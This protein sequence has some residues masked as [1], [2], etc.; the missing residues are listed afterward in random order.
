MTSP[1]SQFPTSVVSHCVERLLER[2]DVCSIAKAK[3]LYLTH[4]GQL[5]RGEG[6]PLFEKQS[7]GHPVNSVTFRLEHAGRYF[8]PTRILLGDRWVIST[9]LSPAMVLSSMIELY[10]NE[11][12]GRQYGLHKCAPA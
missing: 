2:Y 12:G 11:D 3:E 4:H 9:Y 1:I 10:I 8:Y 7:D 5:V 6:K